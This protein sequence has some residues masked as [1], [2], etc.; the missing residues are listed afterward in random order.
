MNLENE[1]ENNL[2][3]E[4]NQIN[5][6]NTMLGKTINNALDIGLRS[7]L[8]DLIEN[9]IIDIKNA[10]IENGL[11]GGIKSAVNSTV[12]FAKSTV[13][14]VTGKFENLE[15]IN[16]AIGNGGIIE[17]ISNAFDF[18]L[19]KIYEN[20]YINSTINSIIKNGKNIIL[21]NITNNIKKEMDSQNDI[22]NIL[23]KNI[24]EWKK[25]YEKKDLEN[26]NIVFNNIERYYDKVVPLE[27]IINE[28]KKIENIHKFIKNKNDNLDISDLEND[29][30]QKFSEI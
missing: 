9:Q 12:D 22:V 24:I 20:G 30:I 18:A 14:I 3:T 27:K 21:D 8:P 15:Q 19:N 17:T 4:K 10:L 13:G 25:Y 5:F 6:L 23:R 7:L 28:I 1:I 11:I 16:I 26:M 2:K 29:L